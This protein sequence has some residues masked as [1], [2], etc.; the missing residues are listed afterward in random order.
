MSNSIDEV[1]S[2]VSNVVDI[3]KQVC[4]FAATISDRRARLVAPLTRNSENDGTPLLRRLFN[5][6][7]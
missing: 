5:K 2:P 7:L 6:F 1:R 3:L 4:K